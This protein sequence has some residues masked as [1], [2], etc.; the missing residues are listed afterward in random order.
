MF[1]VQSLQEKPGFPRLFEVP[2]PVL[3]WLISEHEST[4]YERVVATREYGKFKTTT[5][6]MYLYHFRG[7]ICFCSYNNQ[8]VQQVDWYTMRT[9]H[10]CP[11]TKQC[12]NLSIVI[13]ISCRDSRK[14]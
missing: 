3:G 11:S 13:Q 5:E 12:Y 7:T 4:V 10:V 14:Q 6:I 8:A 1:A 2:Q 9:S